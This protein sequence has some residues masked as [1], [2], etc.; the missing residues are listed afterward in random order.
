MQ[1]VYGGFGLHL[2]TAWLAMLAQSDLRH[3][4]YGVRPL[5][6]ALRFLHL[7]GTAGFVGAILLA[8]IKLL[9][10]FPNA[11]LQPMRI[12]MLTVMHVAFGVTIVTGLTLFL[13]DPI[14]IGLH[15]MFVPK[16]LLVVLGLGHAHGVRRLSAARTLPL[17]KHGLPAISLTIWTL[18]IAC[19]TWNHVERPFN[20]GA[21][22]RL[23]MR[24]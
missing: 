7:L 24:R 2:P 11:S 12:P 1:D 14:G 16:L 20:P 19:S 8:D 15:T 9:G 5:Y 21:I 22:Q 17:L 13:Y 23:E 10:F 3:M 4:I 6:G 18:V